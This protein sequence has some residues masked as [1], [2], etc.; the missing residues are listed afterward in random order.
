MTTQDIH[1]KL[2]FHLSSMGM[3][4]PP[5]EGLLNILKANFSKAEAEVALLIPSHKIPLQ[6][7]SLAEISKTSEIAM[8]DLQKILN[9]LVDKGL[10]FS[11]KNKETGEL[12]YALHQAG[13]GFPQTFFWK[14][15]VT[16]H[17]KSMAKQVLGYFNSEVT[18][19]TFGPEPIPFRFVPVDETIEPGTQA[20]LPYQ[21]ME[22]IIK[23]AN[24]IAVAYCMCRHSMKLIGR[25]CGHPTEVCMKFN[26][27]ADYIIEKGFAREISVEEALEISKKA[28]EN[29]LVHFTDNAIGNVQQNC[30]CCGC[31]C[32][33]LG[34][35][36]RRIIPRD[37]IIATYFIRETISENC[38]GCGNCIDICPADAVK[39]EENLAV[40][41]NNW[42]IGCGVCVSKCPN[43]AIIIVPRGDIED[44]LPEKDFQT[45]HNKILKNR[46]S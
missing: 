44:K 15:E 18:K 37:E 46:S 8:E 20:V 33:N 17:S 14:G 31:S 10:L 13:F 2:M 32:W 35:I 16:P 38:V 6:G 27:L 21:A 43:K 29:G 42:C 7:T 9:T 11:C 3:M 24:R 30:N 5:R 28:S 23:T 36:K 1:E 45:L 4:Y 34:R 41:D 39:L 25:D 22:Q 12:G 40:V 19:E 26:E